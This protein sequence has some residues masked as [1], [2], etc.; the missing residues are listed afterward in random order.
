M[1]FS[2]MIKALRGRK[3]WLKVKRRYDVEKNGIY[4]IVMPDDDREFNE[5]ALRHV[6]DFLDYRKA[7]SAVILTTD[8]W[9]A[10]NAQ[11]FSE[12][13]AA[14]EMM[15]QSDYHF[16]NAYY[17][18]QG[19]SV[20]FIMASLQGDHG[21]RLAL[22]QDVNGITKEDMACLGLYIIRDWT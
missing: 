11:T 20:Q 4:V 10:D 22:A 14:T 15:T 18:Y 5:Y 19:F 7:T 3:R 6:D 2:T 17:Y 1:I 9:T 8:E 12:R 13:I 21:K 16:F